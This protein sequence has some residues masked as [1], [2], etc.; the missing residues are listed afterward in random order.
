LRMICVAWDMKRLDE[1]G[2]PEREHAHADP[3]ALVSVG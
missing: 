3:G 2:W 1:G